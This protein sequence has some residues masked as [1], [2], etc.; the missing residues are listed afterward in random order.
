MSPR[1]RM[2]NIHRAGR[3]RRDV[4]GR[5]AGEAERGPYLGRTPL[6]L[7]STDRATLRPVETAGRTGA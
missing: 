7:G 5:M 2:A 3:I 6:A 4:V 1:S